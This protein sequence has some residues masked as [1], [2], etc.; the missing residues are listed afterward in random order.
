MTSWKNSAIAG[1]LALVVGLLAL[2]GWRRARREGQAIWPLVLPA[3]YLN[4]LL[5]A[6]LALGR[7][8]APILPPLLVLAALG[9]DSLLAAR[10][11]R[12]A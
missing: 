9:V 5:A 6:L 2:V 10:S 3:L 4:L 7:Y 1:V 12:R 11:P 8:S